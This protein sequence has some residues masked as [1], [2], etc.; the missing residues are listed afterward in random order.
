MIRG[1]A[2][3]SGNW[4]TIYFTQTWYPTLPEEPFVNTGTLATVLLIDQGGGD[5]GGT[6]GIGIGP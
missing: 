4:T 5:A 2:H 6:G 1:S 3:Q